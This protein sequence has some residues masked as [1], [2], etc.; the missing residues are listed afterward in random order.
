M[1]DVAVVGFAQ[2]PN[3]R[4]VVLRPG[5]S[6]ACFE[7]EPCDPP[8]VAA[9]VVFSRSGRTVARARV[10]ANGGFALHLAPGLYDVVT[11]PAQRG[12]LTP[13]AIRVPRLGVIRLRLVLRT[14]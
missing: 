4:G 3:V 10:G 14:P 13:S 5:A 7:G 11:A 6:G 1:R 12:R 9:F 8:I 2:A